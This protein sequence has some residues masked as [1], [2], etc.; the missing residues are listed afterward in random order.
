M[1]IFETIRLKLGSLNAL[2][3]LA[4]MG[5]VSGLLAGGV[6][7][8]FRLFIESGIVL[9][10]R[11][12]GLTDFEMTPWW[13]RLSLPLV[14][15][16]L[17][18]FVLHKVGKEARQVGVGHVLERMSFHQGYIP[19][20]NAVV[21]FLVGGMTLASGQ[22]VGREG[23]GIHLGS[24]A[25]SWLGQQM[26]LP[27]NSIRILVGCGTAAAISAS[28]NT[29]LAGVI[30]AM[31][32]V[33]ME[34]AVTSF[35]PLIL[36]SVSAAILSR[37]VFGNDVAFI[38]PSLELESLWEIP[39]FILLGIIIGCF[40]SLFI[41][42]TR[43][44]SIKAKN[45]SSWVKCGTAGTC[46]GLIALVAPQVMGIGYDTVNSALHGSLP[47]Q[48]LLIAFIGK[49]LATIICSGMS[50][51][52]GVIGP[53]MFIG[54]MIGGAIGSIGAILFPEYAS[55]YA[56][57]S[58]VGMGTMMSAVLQAPLAALMALLELTNNPNIL[59]PGMLS[60]VIANLVVSQLFKQ[61]SIFHSQMRV[62][63]LEL[64][65]NPLSQFLRSVGVAGLMERKIAV[66]DRTIT[67]QEAENVLE[68]TPRW[69]LI[70]QDEV[71][72]SLMAAN[73]LARYILEKR[74]LEAE[75]REA[76]EEAGEM[77]LEDD[78][79]DVDLMKIPADRQNIASVYLQG[80][81]EEALDTMD[82]ETVDAVYIFRTTGPMT[83]KIYGVL[84]REVIESHY[85]YKR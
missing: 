48:I 36:S 67:Y 28:F 13:F 71:P 7:I 30:F 45:W 19:W 15:G 56:F 23:P 54:A 47:L 21:Q 1:S 8:L 76:A 20:R 51:P 3:I 16:F 33:M 25:G 81:L 34:Y 65:V 46:V 66:H 85:S 49:F 80:N 44:V 24:A 5:L 9:W 31:E 38:V 11:G 57:Y 26:K 39:Y 84:T 69:I 58:M 22:S 41:K 52:G 73:D 43:M 32:I 50:L 70:K 6:V 10:H 74:E 62:K 27:N 12:E 42:A 63:G 4:V 61:P 79:P 14:G 37:I 75:Q 40:A 53:S 60:L 64:K 18:G 59:L 29:P 2:P 35:I 17:V 72:I 55:D 68:N 82:R 83:D 78:K 77:F